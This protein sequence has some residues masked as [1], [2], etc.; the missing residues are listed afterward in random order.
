MGMF[1]GDILPPVTTARPSLVLLDKQDL[2]RVV[3][4]ILCPWRA[5][6]NINKMVTRIKHKTKKRS[7]ACHQSLG[8]SYSRGNFKFMKSLIGNKYH[9]SYIGIEHYR[10]SLV[11]IKT[12]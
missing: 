11:N 6:R 7:I 1:C 2:W 9:K 8:F 10:W 4:I 3:A 5:N 12:K